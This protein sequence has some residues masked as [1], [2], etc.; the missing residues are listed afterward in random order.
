MHEWVDRHPGENWSTIARRAGMPRS[1]VHDWATRETRRQTPNPATLE[2]LL[3]GMP[4]VD[5]IELRQA[6]ADA[7]GYR[8]EMPDEANTPEGRLLVTTFSKLDDR[9][10]EELCARA[11]Y[12]FQEMTEANGT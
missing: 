1:T 11:R 8:F 3:V 12:L 10:R 2:R 5:P 7:A 6:A 9:R 4:G